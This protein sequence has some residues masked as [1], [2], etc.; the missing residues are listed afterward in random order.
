MKI[1]CPIDFSQ[2]SVHALRYALHIFENAEDVEVT[3]IH[4]FN[5]ASRSAMFMKMDAILRENAI[6]DI[7]GLI[8]KMSHKYEKI[9]FDYKIYKGDPKSIIPAIVGKNEFDYIVIGTKGMSQLKELVMGSLTKTL[10]ENCEAPILAIPETI[11]VRKPKNMLMA[12]DSKVSNISD[13]NM[14]A[15]ENVVRESDSDL[16][17]CHVREDDKKDSE[18][19]YAVSG[20]LSHLSY[21]FNTIDMKKDLAETLEEE[22]KSKE[23]DI[24][25]LMHRQRT[26]WEKLFT[27]SF[28]ASELF[29]LDHA[30]LV[31][32][33][34]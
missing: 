3:L 6:K 11:E 18:V 5:L 15:L 33:T 14:K 25:V 32:S 23:A 10:I 29:N 13:V 12:L 4:C 8:K 26:W 24:L 28:T 30:L 9:K 31:L 19:H 21:Q 17:V 1:L 20:E 16:Y 27:Q 22:M 34:E 2:N 7:N